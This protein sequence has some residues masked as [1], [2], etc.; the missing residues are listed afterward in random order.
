LD[1]IKK[2]DWASIEAQAEVTRFPGLRQMETRILIVEDNTMDVQLLRLALQSDPDWSVKITVVEDGEEAINYFLHPETAKPDLVILD[3]NLPKR[4]GFE[5]LRVIRITNYLYGLPVV[6]FSSSTEDV[7]RT[8]MQD[9][10]L[11]PE[12]Y[13]T[14]PVGIE[15]FLAIGPTLKRYYEQVTH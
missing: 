10:K 11:A 3:L 8:K 4:D 1:I 9:A 13:L 7:I 14:K 5:V 15:E 6:V 2:V 12:Y